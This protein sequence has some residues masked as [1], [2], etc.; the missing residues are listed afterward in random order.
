MGH[1]DSKR[2]CQCSS[3]RSTPLRLNHSG[4]HP[5]ERASAEMLD[6]DGIH[7]GVT[8]LSVLYLTYS[9]SARN[10]VPDKHWDLLFH[11]Q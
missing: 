6:A 4:V 3:F 2:M 10:L 9:Y 8:L 7:T 1:V 11:S 5:L